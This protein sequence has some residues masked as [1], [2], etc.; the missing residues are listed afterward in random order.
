MH[1]P[2]FLYVLGYGGAMLSI[3]M[4]FPLAMSVWNGNMQQGQ[5]FVIGLLLSVFVSGSFLLAGFQ[6]RRLRAQNIELLI[7]MILFWLVLPVLAAIPLMGAVQINSPIGAYFEAVSA[8]TTSGGTQMRYP[9]W[10]AP[11]ILLWR[12]LLAWLG[13][14]WTLVFSVGV[15]APYAIGGLALI[16]NPLLQHD[17]NAPLASRLGRPL[18]IILPVYLSLTAIGVLAM[19][20]TGQGVFDA[21]T[22][23]MSSLSTTGFINDSTFSPA[24]MNMASQ[25]VIT[26]L[27]LTGALSLPLLMSV[28]RGRYKHL[29]AEVEFRVFILLIIGFALVSWLVLPS[30][31]L[32]TL[33]QSISLSTTAGFAFLDNTALANWPMV[34][35]M[36]PSL[37]GGM[38]LS[39]AGGIKV[40][41]AIILAKDIGSELE[42]LAY[43]SSV[44][45]MT[46]NGRRLDQRNFSAAWSFFAVYLLFVTLA[47]LLTGLFGISLEQAWPLVLG[48]AGNSLSIVGNLGLYTDFAGLNDSLKITLSLLMIAGRIEFLVILILFTGAFWRLVR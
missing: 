10:E 33:F 40:M 46:L 4:L 39:T 13:A 45:P 31:L 9:E 47:V 12:M 38:A 41:R 8:L 43:P 32:A 30:G 3:L 23:T 44:N 34:W 11:S 22:L 36:V 20:A 18:F 26:L 21:L 35:I 24:N 25:T 37:I 2:A 17:E 5:G 16:G 1:L 42:R 29:N 7:L 14:L 28:T 15:L 19:L 27:T 48:A 6:A